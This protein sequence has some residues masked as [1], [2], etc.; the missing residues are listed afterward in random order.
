[1]APIEIRFSSA[2]DHSVIIQPGREIKRRVSGK[3]DTELGSKRIRLSLS[4]SP[5]DKSGSVTAEIIGVKPRLRIG[6]LGVMEKRTVLDE[7]TTTV[8]NGQVRFIPLP[9]DDKGFG[10]YIF[11]KH[12][13]GK[14]NN[15]AL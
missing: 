8:Q 10:Y 2:P 12:K 7:N 6:R 1:M 4:C 13:T 14:E 3:I 11:L 5:D 9:I 15:L